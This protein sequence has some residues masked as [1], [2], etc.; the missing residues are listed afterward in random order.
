MKK[1]LIPE[2]SYEK[3]EQSPESLMLVQIEDV[4]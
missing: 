3:W 1:S 4:E 2:C